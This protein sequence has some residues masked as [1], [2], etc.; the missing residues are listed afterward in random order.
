[1]R[2]VLGRSI[3][4]CI[5]IDGYA[6]CFIHIVYFTQIVKYDLILKYKGVNLGES[7]ERINRIKVAIRSIL[8]SSVTVETIHHEDDQVLLKI[9]NQEIKA[10][11]VGS[12]WLKQVKNAIAHKSKP[13]IVVGR[14]ISPGSKEEL[15]K[16]KIGWV[17]ETGDVSISIGTI[18]ISKSGIP[19]EKSKSQGTWNRSV[20]SVAETILCTNETRVEQIQKLTGLSRGSCAKS[21]QTLTEMKY[22]TASVKRGPRSIRSVKNIEQLLSAYADAA[23][24]LAP[25]EKVSLG[26][27]W[28]DPISGILDIGEKWNSES[29]EWFVTGA[30]A[31]SQMAP[32]LTTFAKVEVYIE[33]KTLLELISVGSI[34]NL[35]PIEGGRLILKVI[36]TRTTKSLA[37]NL[38][39]LRVAPWP[40]VYTDL[41]GYGVRG[42]EAAEHLLEELNVK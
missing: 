15:K 18:I 12:G 32:S 16:K 34:A 4:F 42:E 7:I 25:I 3:L 27:S 40:R 19:V 5:I 22:L 26:V 37:K 35:E 6:I 13:D 31:A 21:L 30:A 29:I 1:M 20:L 36:P 39:G 24:L 41:R 8:P 10:K 2:F 28:K 14:R 9:G 33:A 38:G 23:S 17:D 11:W